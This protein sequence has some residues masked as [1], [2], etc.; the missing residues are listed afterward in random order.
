[1]E[2]SALPIVA[3]S[4]VVPQQQ[5]SSQDLVMVGVGSSSLAI[6]QP[7]IDVQYRML[8]VHTQLLLLLSQQS[9]DDHRT[10]GY[11]RKKCS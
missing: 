10:E 6:Q 9:A 4:S 8:Q 5:Q 7:E 1:M 3:S 2:P 11:C